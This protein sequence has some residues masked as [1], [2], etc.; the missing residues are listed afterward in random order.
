MNDPCLR[1][2][3]IPLGSRLVVGVSGGADSVALLDILAREWP[4]SQKTLT[5][6]HVNYG[7]RKKDSE[8][9]E[10][11][12]RSLCRERKIQLRVLKFKDFKNES[13]LKKK[14]L[15]D[16][17]REVRYSFFARLA[18]GKK[19]WGAVAA[20][21]QEDQAETVLDRLLRGAGPRG[22]S[23]LRT[24]QELSVPP[25]MEHLKI[26][27]PFLSYSKSDLREYLVR[28]GISWRE[29]E[30]NL[31]NL[32]RRNQIRNQVLPYLSKW[33]PALAQT[34]SRVGEITAVEDQFLETLM[35]GM[36]KRVK[37]RW[38]GGTIQVDLKAIGKFHLALKRRFIR[39]T[40]EKLNVEARGLSY[41]GIQEILRLWEGQE[42]GPRDIGYDLTAG[43]RGKT[44]F[45]SRKAQKASFH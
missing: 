28:R 13:K 19:A 40:A 37:S 8:K 10:E 36:A 38:K 44:A 39:F 35:S 5:A 30:S 7:L 4:R 3:P 27:R 41:K 24:V 15:Q 42:T 17:A 14:S 43:V 20:H 22:L 31:Q 21:H 1:P 9:D 32:Y 11:W 29:D 18:K 6:A 33:N 2:I 23:G 26:W 34:L 45:L 16:Y 25:R 12:V